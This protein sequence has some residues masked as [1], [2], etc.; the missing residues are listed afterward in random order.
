[1]C[2]RYRGGEPVR[3][4][5]SKHTRCRPC[6]Q[7]VLAGVRSQ[8]V[9]LFLISYQLSHLRGALSL[10]QY[11][12]LYAR[13]LAGRLL[14]RLP[15]RDHA[16]VA[17]L[18]PVAAAAAAADG[19][20]LPAGVDPAVAATAAPSLIVEALVMRGRIGRV[21]TLMREF[22]EL[23]SDSLALTYAAKGTQA[24]RGAARPEQ[25]RPPRSHMHGVQPLHL[26]RGPRPQP[27][28]AMPAT[29]RTVRGFACMWHAY[30]CTREFLS[31]Y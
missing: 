1:M 16:A 2:A 20:D 18:A 11:H 27:H 22:P 31:L 28:S 3:G 5:L 23:Q 24:V 12:A 7:R 10:P 8:P 30:V 25:R 14:V 29:T 17:A 15:P 6:A 21:R 13:E 9:R 19:A 26:S 4:C